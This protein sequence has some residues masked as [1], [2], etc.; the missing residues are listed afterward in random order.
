MIEEQALVIGVEG[1]SAMLEIVRRSPCGLCGQT[2]GCGVSVFGRLLGHRNNVFKAVN[3]LN[4]RIG[5]HVVVGVDEKALLASSLMVYGIPLALLLA[6]AA[7]GTWLAP[8]G[9]DVWPLAGAG[10]GLSVGLLWLRSRATK[11]GLDARYRP[12]ILRQADAHSQIKICRR[13]QQ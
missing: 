11:R 1:D 4:A 8:T 6:G 13:G 10:L 5:D 9:G 2:R 3:I 12:V 7:V